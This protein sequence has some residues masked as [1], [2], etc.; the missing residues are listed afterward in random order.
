MANRKSI[1]KSLRF[2]VF[3]RDK[4]TC[5]YC[6][7]SAP[8]VVLEVDHLKPVAKGGTNDILNLITACKDCNRGKGAKELSDNSTV[9]K[10]QKIIQD[11]AEKNE[12][13]QMMLEWK[14]QLRCIH[15][16]ETD[17]AL[18]T[19]SAVTGYEINE[20]GKHLLSQC[21]KRFGIE[22]VL[23][24]IDIAADKYFDGSQNGAERCFSMI[25]KICST[26]KKSKENPKIYYYNY[27]K[28]VLL[29]RMGVRQ[30]PQEEKDEL[31]MLIDCFID[32]DEDFEVLKRKLKTLTCWDDFYR[33]SFDFEFGDKD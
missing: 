24:S 2:E 3:K 10:Q 5:Q 16:K 19:F 18:E 11:L 28:K 26:R 13:L 6:G 31:D 23:E 20:H 12:Q 1:S 7:K 8:D 9:K 33:I 4:F 15:D 30:L 25:P 21:I 27:T 32:T 22:E 14:E 17:G 29:S